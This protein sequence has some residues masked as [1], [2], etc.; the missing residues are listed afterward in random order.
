MNILRHGATG[1]GVLYLSPVRVSV[2]HVVVNEDHLLCLPRVP[3]GKWEPR[4]DAPA[5]T[6]ERCAALVQKAGS[7]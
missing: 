2:I 6:C 3:L 7:C 5:P 1:L 4:P